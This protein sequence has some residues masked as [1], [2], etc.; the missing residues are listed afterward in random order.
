MARLEI[1]I[2]VPISPTPSLRR[3]FVDKG[4]SSHDNGTDIPRGT[5]VIRLELI[6]ILARGEPPI[7]GHKMIER[8]ETANALNGQDLGELILANQNQIEEHWQQFTIVLPGTIWKQNSSSPSS[9]RYR[10]VP[11]LHF[12]NGRW[13]MTL[14]WLDGHWGSLHRLVRIR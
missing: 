8:A 11:C 6:K 12:E 9:Y 4:L 13:I 2:Q 5:N 7:L 3:Q 10:F 14:S 1:E